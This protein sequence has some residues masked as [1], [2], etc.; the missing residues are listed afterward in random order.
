MLSANRPLEPVVRE[1][2]RCSFDSIV[3]YFDKTPDNAWER[4][5]DRNMNTGRDW[6]RT[7]GVFD[8][9]SVSLNTRSC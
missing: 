7:A 2:V 5:N 8:H 3:D 4:G 6:S 1:Q 9:P